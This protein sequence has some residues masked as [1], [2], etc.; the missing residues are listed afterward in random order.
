MFKKHDY[1]KTLT[2]LTGILTRLYYGEALGIG[3][4]AEEFGVSARTIQRDFNERLIGFP[5]E[6]AGQ[7]WRMKSGHAITH[8]LGAEEAIT[9][10]ILR[11]L[12][13]SVGRSFHTRANR[14][15]KKLLAGESGP[16]YIRGGFEEIGHRLSEVQLLE[17]CIR[18]RKKISFA[19]VSPKETKSVTVW[20]LKIIS[21]E[22]YWYLMAYDPA[23]NIYK[24]YYLPN[25]QEPCALEESFE[26]PPDVGDRVE[27]AV[28]IWFRPEVEPYEVRLLVTGDAARYLERK[29][30]APTQK[31]LDRHENGNVEISCQ[32]THDMEILP[33]VRYWHPEVL[34][35][36]PDDLKKRVVED[37]KRFLEKMADLGET[38]GY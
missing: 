38:G 36:G 35:I 27:N 34:V 2:R 4:L 22:G 37:A 11:Q 16:F 29:P 5:I 1:D 32:I 17:E 30:F 25:M 20:P 24:K 13:K 15:L 18:N 7:K 19:Y 3:D 23:T 33:V 21:F 31:I 9:L 14:V 6:K 26:L 12:S 10:E 28:N 8:M